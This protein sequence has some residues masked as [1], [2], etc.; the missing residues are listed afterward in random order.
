MNFKKKKSKVLDFSGSAKKI[1][2]N[3]LIL[4]NILMPECDCNY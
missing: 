2:E 3:Q 1:M 4:K